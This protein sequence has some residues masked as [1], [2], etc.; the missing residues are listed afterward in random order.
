M[1][2]SS[3]IHVLSF[4]KSLTTSLNTVKSMVMTPEIK[5]KMIISSN[6]IMDKSFLTEGIQHYNKLSDKQRQ[7]EPLHFKHILKERLLD[8]TPYSYDESK[9]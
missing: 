4:T 3:L 6:K 2:R 1:P 7:H 8:L 9:G 5:N